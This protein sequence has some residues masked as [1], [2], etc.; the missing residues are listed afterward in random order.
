MQ[1][2]LQFFTIYMF[3][4]KHNHLRTLS[5][6]VNKQTSKSSANFCEDDSNQLAIP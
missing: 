2:C 6:W 5:Q 1:P 4:M 3:E